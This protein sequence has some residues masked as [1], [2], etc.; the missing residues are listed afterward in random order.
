MYVHGYKELPR[1]TAWL[2]D[3]VFN[4]AGKTF[5]Y[6]HLFVVLGVVDNNKNYR[7]SPE[8]SLNSEAA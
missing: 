5:Y 4:R 2:T 1:V 6:D 3:V 7:K 8:V